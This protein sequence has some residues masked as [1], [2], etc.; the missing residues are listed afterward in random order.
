VFVTVTVYAITACVAVVSVTS[1][2]L[3][4]AAETAESIANPGY[5]CER[6]LT[7]EYPASS[8]HRRCCCSIH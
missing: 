1:L 8:F 7:L 3:T 2:P 5:H 4:A 6:L